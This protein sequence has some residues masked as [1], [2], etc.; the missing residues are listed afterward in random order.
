M[1]GKKSVLTLAVVIGIVA[2]AFQPW[3][4][5]SNGQEPKPAGDELAKLAKARRDAAQKAFSVWFKR[6]ATSPDSAI[7]TTYLL[8]RNWLDAELEIARNQQERIAAF[9]GHLARMKEWT[10]KWR[11]TLE[12]T[13]PIFVAI[14]SFQS[15]AEFWLARERSS[16]K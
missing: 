12:E 5:A 7:P 10:N 6:N 8:S 4:D 9:G 1:L 2:L 3:R 15:E 11:G 14:M 16:K 13:D